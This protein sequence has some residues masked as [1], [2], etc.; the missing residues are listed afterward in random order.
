MASVSHAQFWIRQAEENWAKRDLDQTA[1]RLSAFWKAKAEAW[2]ADPEVQRALTLLDAD[3]HSIWARMEE[4]RAMDADTGSTE[5][6]QH[7]AMAAQAWSKAAS[8]RAQGGASDRYIKSTANLAQA[9]G[10]LNVWLNRNVPDTRYSTAVKEQAG[11]L[12]T[13]DILGVPAWAWA[14][15]GALLVLAIATR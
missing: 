9:A 5:R 12:L 3:A 4:K 8:L 11:N 14:A 2:T 1:A 15:G 10:G 6:A 13:A 7:S